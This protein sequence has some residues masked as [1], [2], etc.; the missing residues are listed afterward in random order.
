[1]KRKRCHRQVNEKQQNENRSPKSGQGLE[2]EKRALA[3]G[4]ALTNAGVCYV[5]HAPPGPQGHLDQGVGCDRSLGYVGNVK[6]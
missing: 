6:M 5:G 3:A 1:M 4:Q 2:T